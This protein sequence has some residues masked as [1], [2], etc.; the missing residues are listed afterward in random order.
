MEIN[1][2]TILPNTT[3]KEAI[4]AIQ[5]TGKK[6]VLITDDNKVLVGIFTDGDMRRHVLSGGDLS[7]KISEAMNKA[8]RV[9]NNRNEAVEFSNNAV[10]I[11]G[12]VIGVAMV[13]GLNYLMDRISSSGKLKAKL[14]ETFAEFFARYEI[15][16]NEKS[17]T[18]A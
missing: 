1:K 9:F 11:I 15:S 6:I 16:A 18:R 8:P 5:A 17:P 4:E 14:H 3:V 2:Y 7:A 13:W 10:A 12:L